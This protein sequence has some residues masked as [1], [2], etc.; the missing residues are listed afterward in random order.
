MRLAMAYSYLKNT[1]KVWLKCKNNGLHGWKVR[2]YRTEARLDADFM[3]LMRDC[4]YKNISVDSIAGPLYSAM[5]QNEDWEVVEEK[6][7]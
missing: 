5:M 4:E 6:N 3:L 7:D 2:L 1:D